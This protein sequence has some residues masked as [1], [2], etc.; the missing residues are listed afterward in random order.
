ML[1][2]MVRWWHGRL[3]RMDMN[4]LWPQCLKA[5]GEMGL[6]LDEAKAAFAHHVFCDRAW[7]DEFHPDQLV[8]FVDQLAPGSRRAL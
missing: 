7:I 4:V 1:R 2:K 5:S 3:R 6:G 8:E